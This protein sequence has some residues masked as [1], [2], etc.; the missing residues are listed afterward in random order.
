MLV[1]VVLVVLLLSS[2]H[3]HTRTA[4]AAAAAAAATRTHRV[5]LPLGEH[6]RLD[7]LL[8]EQV[9]LPRQRV[10]LLLLLFLFI[11][12]F[13]L[14]LI[15]III[16]ITTTIQIIIYNAPYLCTPSG[17][18]SGDIKRTIIKKPCSCGLGRA[19]AL[20]LLLLL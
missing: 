12:I 9:A 15:F 14:I 13:I 3:P 1:L 10:L 6:V 17:C 20:L 19:G 2:Y 5:C 11:F 18:K 8:V 7:E 16:I 4:A